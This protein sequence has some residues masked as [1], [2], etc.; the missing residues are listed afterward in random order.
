MD[1]VSIGLGLAGLGMQLFGG[2]GAASVSR[3]Q[4]QV[5]AD[6]A[7]Q[8]EQIN[9][10]KQQQMQLEYQRSSLQNFRATQ[11]AHARNLAAATSEGA[12]FG[13]GLAGGQAGATAEG[14]YNQLGLNQNYQVGM[15][16]NRLNSNI[17]SDRI[18][19][20]QLGGQAATDQGIASLGGAIMHAGPTVGAFA[21]QVQSSGFG[22][23]F[24][25]P[26]V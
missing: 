19:L 24:A 16:I 12:Q 4:A 10:Q 18:Q 17:S 7:G 20:A 9:Q 3:Q 8:E 25:G 1:P 13:S 26:Y 11:Q 22:F 6:I 14:A 23:G 5:S 15:N 21:K 2:F